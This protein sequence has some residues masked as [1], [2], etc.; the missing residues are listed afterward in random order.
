MNYRECKN[1]FK[2]FLNIKYPND[3]F[4][5][6]LEKFKNFN[7]T[8]LFEGHTEYKKEYEDYAVQTRSYRDADDTFL[9]RMIMYIIWGEHSEN[10]LPSLDDFDKIGNGKIYGGE[11]LNTFNTLFKWDFSGIKKFLK[12]LPAQKE[13]DKYLEKVRHFE[14]VYASIG[15]FMLMPGN[16]IRPEGWEKSTSINGYRGISGGLYDY[17]DLFLNVYNCKSDE[18][19]NELMKEDG[20][21]SF[22]FKEINSVDEFCKRNFIDTTEEY[23]YPKNKNYIKYNHKPYKTYMYY[24]WKN[25]QDIEKDHKTYLEFASRYMEESEKIIIHRANTIIDEL[26]KHF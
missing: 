9:A 13:Q 18:V 22:Y 17:F 14:E 6:Q 11:T 7:F 24:G 23:G 10:P 25:E 12:Y 19:L 2:R 4:E 20:V 8:E 16:T 1:E 5:N 21:N 3:T 15:N 26:K